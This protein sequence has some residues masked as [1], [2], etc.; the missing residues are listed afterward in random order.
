MCRYRNEV[1]WLIK[2]S[3]YVCSVWGAGTGHTGFVRQVGCYE[4]RVVVITA[5]G[6]TDGTREADFSLVD[7]K[8]KFVLA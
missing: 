1:A 2:N 6:G 3:Q 4:E 5:V 8:V 7:T